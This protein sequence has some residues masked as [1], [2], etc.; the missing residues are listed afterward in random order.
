MV[1]KKASSGVELSLMWRAASPKIF[2]PTAKKY[3]KLGCSHI[4]VRP[5]IHA[6]S[7]LLRSAV[8]P[9]WHRTHANARPFLQSVANHLL[10]ALLTHVLAQTSG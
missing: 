6:L 3:A 8:T 2:R 1:P 7:R 10:Y 5:T 9:Q 4:P